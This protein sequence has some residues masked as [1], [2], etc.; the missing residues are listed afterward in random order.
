MPQRLPAFGLQSRIA[1]QDQR[2]KIADDRGVAIRQMR[3][4]AT[5]QFV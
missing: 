2:G 4:S 3:S 1:R 5:E